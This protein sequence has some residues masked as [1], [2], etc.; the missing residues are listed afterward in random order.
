VRSSLAQLAALVCLGCLAWQ[1]W[2]QEF[3]NLDF[4]SA[5]IEPAGSFGQVLFAPAFPGWT[6]WIGGALQ[7]YANYDLAFL[8]TAGISILDSN[9]DSNWLMAQLI[10]CMHGHYCAL[11]QSGHGPGGSAIDI[12][13]PVDAAIATSGTIPSDAQTLLFNSSEIPSE[14]LSVAFQGKPIALVVVSNSPNFMVLGG[15]V[16]LFAGQFGELSFTM[17]VIWTTVVPT[18]GPIVLD[19]IRFS[20]APLLAAPVILTPPS[21]AWANLGSTVDLQVFASGSP[22]PVYQW[23]FNGSNLIAGATSSLLELTDIQHSQSGA[24]SV[25]VSNSLG[26]VTSAPALVYAPAVEINAQPQSETINA[27][28]TARFSVQAQSQLFLSYQWLKNGNLLNDAGNTSGS[29][30]ANLI[31][32]NVLKGDEGSYA[33][34]IGYAGYGQLESEAAT[35]SV[36]DPAIISQPGSL[37]TAAGAAVSFTVLACGTPPLLCQWFQNASPIAAATTSA[38]LLTNVQP[39]QNGAYCVVVTN[40]FGPVTSSVA[41]LSVFLPGNLLPPLTTSSPYDLRFAGVP[42]RSYSLQRALTLS[43]P[44]T[45]LG[46]LAVAADAVGVFQDPSPP[47]SAAF[48]RTRYP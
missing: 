37:S 26:A 21:S 20:P 19:D 30:T 12:P 17:N 33:V 46:T 42:G 43:G 36:V 5:S 31:I 16:S 7:L 2:G 18:Y 48:Y 10:D 4:E 28:Q 39:A 3:Q 15:D 32:S 22:A 41:F 25:V 29:P 13:P 23:L 45:T 38:L 6:G 11:I 34:N 24:Y 40:V 44:W 1:A 47:R 27:G 8:D 14:Y 9:C 35:L